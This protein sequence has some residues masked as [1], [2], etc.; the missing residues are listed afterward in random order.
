MQ[1]AADNTSITFEGNTINA[2]TGKGVMFAN[3][4]KKPYYFKEIQVTNN[5]FIGLSRNV[6]DDSFKS[7]KNKKIKGNI[8]R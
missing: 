4:S 8:Y 6:I 1:E 7:V 3:Y 5:T 2:T